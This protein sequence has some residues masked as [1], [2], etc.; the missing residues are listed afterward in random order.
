[1][2]KKA[3]VPMYRACRTDI[4]RTAALSPSRNFLMGP[5]YWYRPPL[6]CWQVGLAG[7]MPVNARHLYTCS[8]TWKVA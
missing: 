5:R 7:R 2:P 4:R 3:F 6:I 1:M 8:V